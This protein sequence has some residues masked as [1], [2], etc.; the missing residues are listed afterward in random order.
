M[1]HSILF[2]ILHLLSQTAFS[3]EV[4]SVPDG[5]VTPT[6]APTAPATAADKVIILT[7]R[8]NQLMSRVTELEGELSK[9]KS[10]ASHPKAHLSAAHFAPKMETVKVKPPVSDETIL[11]PVNEDA[12]LVFRK[13][14]ALYQTS[15]YPEAILEWTRFQKDYPDHV[16]A[17][18][19]QFYLGDSYFKQN[20]YKLSSIEFQKVL[21]SYD[22]S[23]HVSDTLER[24]TVCEEKN[25][26]SVQSSKHKQMLKGLFAHSPAGMSGGSGVTHSTSAT[27]ATTAKNH[28]DTPPGEA[29]LTAPMTGTASKLKLDEPEEEEESKEIND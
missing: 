1:T 25:G 26:N 29:P 18:S 2:T 12:I 24:L 3:A 7:E 15:K 14:Y 17:G 6:T 22:R 8:V 21:V 23:S 5:S 19:A 27:S 4:D 28:L 20:E 9:L 16:L 11:A 10:G 13:A